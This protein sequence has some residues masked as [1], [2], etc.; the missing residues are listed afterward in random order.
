MPSARKTPKPDSTEPPW[1]GIGGGTPGW[2]DAA[3]ICP[4]VLYTVYGDRRVLERHYDGMK[5]W[6]EF[7][8]ANNPDHLCWIGPDP[9]RGMTFFVRESLAPFNSRNDGPASPQKPE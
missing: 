6:V 4:W 7:V 9:Q 8:A 3:I 1:P 5:R 2:A